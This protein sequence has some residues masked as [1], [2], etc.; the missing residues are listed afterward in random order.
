[1]A[2]YYLPRFTVYWSK[3]SRENGI[4]EKFTRLAKRKGLSISAL[5]L[6]AI[7]HYV[8]E[9]EKKPSSTENNR[10]SLE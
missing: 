3:K 6:E 5:A 10:T 1:M 8:K 2:R 9:Q 4:P 7:T